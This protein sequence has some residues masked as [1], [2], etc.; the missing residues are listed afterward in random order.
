MSRGSIN[1]V[2]FGA[3]G[4]VGSA[5]KDELLAAGHFVRALDRS[6]LQEALGEYSDAGSTT[7]AEA[8]HQ[9]S[10]HLDHLVQAL[11]GCEVVVNAA[12]A[13]SPN[14]SHLA[15][16]FEANVALPAVLAA[17]CQRTPSRSKLVHVSSAAVQGA[18]RVLD[19]SMSHAPS[20]PYGLSKAMAEKGLFELASSSFQ[21]II[22]RPTSV[23]HPSRTTTKRMSKLIQMPL[24]PVIGA[25]EAQIPVTT[26]GSVA[27]ATRLLVENEVAGGPVLHPWEGVTQASLLTALSGRRLRLRLPGKSR[28]VIRVALGACSKTGPR[29]AAAARRAELLLL[30][31][32]TNATKLLDLGFVPETPET[33]LEAIGPVD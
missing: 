10:A 17:A 28:T 16:V 22:Y 4:F 25:G 20:T 15:Q 3:S 12:G 11:S 26:V 23:H 18:M 14:A 2:L 1:V 27:R 30:G 21:P 7:F 6:A 8:Y 5:I 29:A 24:I 32:S 19:E 33:V 13:A 9:S 31:Q